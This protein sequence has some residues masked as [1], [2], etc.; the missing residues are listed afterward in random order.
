MEEIK[1]EETKQG[2]LIIQPVHKERPLTILPP[3]HSQYKVYEDFIKHNS[4]VRGGPIAVYLTP[5]V[6]KKYR[7]IKE[8]KKEEKREGLKI[9]LRFEA[10]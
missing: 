3:N 10:E 6:A 1:K 8:E 5:E 4:T 7:I 2:I 9:N